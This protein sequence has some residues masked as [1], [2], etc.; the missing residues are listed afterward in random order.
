MKVGD[1]LQPWDVSALSA[2]ARR[3]TA[4]GDERAQVEK[5]A[6][7]FE[8]I[9][10]RTWL[11]SVRNSSIEPQ[12]ELTSG[13]RALA[14]DQLAAHFVNQGGFGLASSLVDQMMKQIELR[15]QA[16]S[17]SEAAK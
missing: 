3:L 9:L 16:V 11:A 7:G 15:K 13:Y 2:D 1:S 6:K 12:S 10:A 17:V 5:A 14:D 8:L 4:I